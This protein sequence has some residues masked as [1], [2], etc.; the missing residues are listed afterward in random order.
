MIKTV[1]WPAAFDFPKRLKKA[2]LLIGISLFSIGLI[3]TSFIDGA[4]AQDASK[5]SNTYNNDSPSSSTMSRGAMVNA[6]V[7]SFA[8]RLHKN[9]GTLKEWMK[10]VRFYKILG[11]NDKA[12]EALAD[13]KKNLQANPQAIKRLDRFAK[14]MG[15]KS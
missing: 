14:F 2:T 10:L 11:K 6:N 7:D 9:G 3:T 1:A 12:L 13:A 5:K 4:V 15:L 8:E